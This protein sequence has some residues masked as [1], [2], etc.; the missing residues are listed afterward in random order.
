MLI[1]IDVFPSSLMLAIQPYAIKYGLVEEYNLKCEIH[2][3]C[4]K[5]TNPLEGRSFLD[6][7][8]VIESVS[9]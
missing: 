9:S 6:V 7:E 3:G 1:L 4:A 8:I 2:T 5:Y